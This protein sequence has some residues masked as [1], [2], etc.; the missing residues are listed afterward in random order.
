M[1]GEG[2]EVRGVIPRSVEYLFQCLSKKSATSEVAMVCSFLE[3][4]NDQIRDLGKA[5][6]ALTMNTDNSNSALNEKTSDIFESLAGKRGNPY[7]A[8]AF[9]KTNQGLTGFLKDIQDEYNTMNYE[10]RED[11]L[12]NVFVKDL[13][14]I[15]V[16]TIEDVMSLIAAGLKVRATH[17]TKMNAFS[18]RSHTVFTITVLQK[19]KI[20]EESVVGMLNLV[21]LA[22]SERLK[23]SESVGVRLKEALHINSSLTALGK[24][25][26]ALDPALENSHIPYRDSKLT[27]VLQNS[28]GGN[29]HTTVIAT[30]HPNANY[31]EECLSSLQF[32]NRCRN[33]R[34]N[35]R[36]NYVKDDEDKDRKIKKLMDELGALRSKVSQIGSGGDLMGHL[37]GGSNNLGGNNKM[38][39]SYL[40]SLLKK[41]GINASLCADGTL[42][43]NG[44][45]FDLS[46]IGLGGS[47]GGGG[48]G[49]D[50]MDSKFGTGGSLIKM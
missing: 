23:K 24:V 15:P 20:T 19:D 17:E 13:S 5:Y 35:P 48:E 50:D 38:N 47:T 11:N 32:A 29:S 46:A 25:I 16:S 30:I 33:V 22:G 39:S 44:Q 14:L 10:I 2:S 1:F 43:V 8:P 49:E 26:T 4:Y 27:R 12:G 21:D 7:F 41:L 37:K 34:N 42:L 3:I 31:Y 36:V 45:K 40:L 9:K 18:S 28:L 6:L